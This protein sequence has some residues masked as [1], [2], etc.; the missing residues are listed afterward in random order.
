MVL[1]A[2]YAVDTVS[3]LSGAFKASFAEEVEVEVEGA[4]VLMMVVKRTAVPPRFSAETP[5]AVLVAAAFA[6]AFA[7]QSSKDRNRSLL[8]AQS[9]VGPVAGDGLFWR[10]GTKGTVARSRPVRGFF[11]RPWASAYRV[12]SGSSLNTFRDLTTTQSLRDRRVKGIEPVS[13]VFEIR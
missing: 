12:C 7:F 6:E 3:I 11:D 4:V 2:P 13:S 5:V 10:F 8:A 9:S 1:P